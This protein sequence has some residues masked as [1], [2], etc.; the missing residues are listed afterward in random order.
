LVELRVVFTNGTSATFLN[1]TTDT[2]GL[3]NFLCVPPGKYELIEYTPKGYV[4][5]KDSDGGSPNEISVDVTRT[6][7]PMNEF[8]DKRLLGFISGTVKEDTN[9][10]NI[11]DLVLPSVLIM[12]KDMNNQVIGTTLTDS[13][14]FYIFS[15]VAPGNFS[16]FEINLA[17][18]PLD[19]S[20][21]DGGDMTM[22][23][24]LLLPG[25]NST[26][27]D[28]VDESCRRISGSV[29]ED[30]NNDDKGDEPLP[31]V[32]VGLLHV[33]SN[34]TALPLMNTTTD[35]N[36]L[37]V[38]SC[39]EAGAYI[40]VEYTPIGYVDVNDTDRG[41]PNI[42][43]V[44][45]SSSNSVNNSFI[46]ELPSSS[47]SVSASPSTCPSSKPSLSFHP[48]FFPQCVAQ[49]KCQPDRIRT[50]GSIKKIKC[51]VPII[52]VAEMFQ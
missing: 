31:Q 30:V 5:V 51:V 39:V 45:V 3:F 36:G 8:V 12:L 52:L 2:S 18:V 23:S 7:S 19:V 26:G 35:S 21:I 25:S 49:H 44:N 28:F 13:N 46:D 10:D 17:S 6:D 48:S 41:D 14:G 33:I 15:R 40:L 20:D 47:P 34:G 27:N 22:I 29:F 43:F 50:V 9:N 42:I 16:V 37:F 38:F 24:V 11:G 32:K 1:T 4:D